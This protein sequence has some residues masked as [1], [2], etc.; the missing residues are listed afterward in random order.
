[1]RP[2]LVGESNPAGSRPEW[3]LYPHPP[4]CAGARL[5]RIL[6]LTR[7]QYLRAFDRVNLSPEPW[8]ARAAGQR[9]HELRRGPHRQFILLGRR[10]ARVFGLEDH[11]PFSVVR[12]VS[13]T[14]RRQ[15]FCL[16][17]HPSG[18]NLIWNDPAAQRWARRLARSLVRSPR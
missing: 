10:V 16:L 4:G 5:Q 7:G 3:A 12:S 8:E 1:M 13:T 9:A 14:G 2:L 11:R 6:G 15:V 18:R 17:P